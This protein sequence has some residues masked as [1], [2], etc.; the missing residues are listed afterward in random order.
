MRGAR[1][2]QNA[3]G[4][5]KGEREPKGSAAR[6]YENAMNYSSTQMTA[7]EVSLHGV[8]TKPDKK[9]SSEYRSP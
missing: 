4:H 9:A 1:L 3:R 6:R 7:A 8:V 5:E 2:S